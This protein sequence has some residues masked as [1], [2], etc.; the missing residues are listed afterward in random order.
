MGKLKKI[1]YPLEGNECIYVHQRVIQ[2]IT[3][4][5]YITDRFV[6]ME[7]GILIIKYKSKK[8]NAHGVMEIND[9]GPDYSFDSRNVLLRS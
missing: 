7:R 6:D 4:T 1:I 3:K 2:G 9:L 8:G 5:A